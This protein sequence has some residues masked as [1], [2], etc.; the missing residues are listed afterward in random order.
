[1]NRMLLALVAVGGLLVLSSCDTDPYCLTCEEEDGGSDA[2]D[3]ATGG[4]VLLVDAPVDDAPGDVGDAGCLGTELCND[5]DDDCDGFVDEGLSTDRDP[6]NCG[7]CGNVCSPPHA[8]AV[9]TDG[10]CMVGDCDVG[11][12]DLNG[13]PADGCEYR[14]LQTADEDILCD[15]RDNDCDGL[16]DE[17][18]EFDTDPDN[19]GSCGRVC[20][21][22][23]SDASCAM[24]VCLVD[25]CEDG[26]FDIDGR[27]DNGCE[28]ACTLADPAEETCNVRD[29]D[30]D[31]IVDE[32]DPGGGEACGIDVGA[33]TIGTTMCV[34]GRVACTD[35]ITPTTELCNGVDD[36]CDGNVDQGNPEGGRLCGSRLGA[37]VQGREVC[38]DGAISCVGEV[39]GSA[40]TCNAIDD[41]CDGM[42][43]EGNPDG[44]AACGE[45][46]GACE[47]G[48]LTCS[49]GG[50]VCMGG[51]S[52]AFEACNSMDDDCDGMVDEGNPGG[53]ALCGTDL[54]QCRPG[55]QTCNAGTV[56]C[57]GEVTG[58]METCNSLDDDCDGSVDEG[59][60]GGGAACGPTTGECTA[61]MLACRSGTFVCEGGTGPNVETCDGSDEDCDGATDEAFN[62]M[63]DPR[64][65]G[66]CGNSCDADFAIGICDGGT[67]AIGG[68]DDGHI[69][70]NGDPSDGCEYACSFAGAEVCNGLDDDCDMVVD[71][72]LTPPANFCLSRGVCTGTTAVCGGA[73]G[74][75]CSYP[76]T[77]EDS[78][79][80]CDTLDNDC[81]GRTDEAYPLA[82]TSCSVGIG[83]CEGVGSYECN[84]TEDGVV[85]NAVPADVPDDE[86]CNALDDD[87]DGLVDEVGVDDLGTSWRDAITADA[88]DTVE[89][90]LGGGSSMLMMQY[91]ASRPDASASS[92]GSNETLAC[93]RPGVLPW[94]SVTWPEARDACCAMNPGGACPGAGAPGWQ[95]CD[96]PD[97]QTSCE[98]GAG[99]CNWAYEAT[100]SSSQPVAC[101]GKE[102][103]SDPGLPGDQDAVA[104]AGAFPM[105]R[106]IWG[107]AGSIYDLSGNVKEW[108]RTAAGSNIYEQRGGA[109]N[110]IEN[111]RACGWDFTVANQ[112]FAHPATG[113]R[114]C[115]Y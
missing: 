61:G 47:A 6:N 104:T 33:C 27:A 102:R 100:C 28:Y 26:F 94:T 2:G 56:E 98:S 37:C 111:G 95:L 48:A 51:V 24:S 75:T 12:L 49:G 14:C 63:S 77:F 114:C 30:C 7:A 36:D 40:E 115:M 93:S 23:H 68:C 88:F 106:A 53:G 55:T 85:C 18:V 74:Y 41:D 107:A 108:T 20:R 42:I 11:F 35:S 46:T 83:A 16:V 39:M 9:C 60:P 90:D 34:M 110:T 15:L 97:W 91:E 92:G 21:F 38:S 79:T 52:P 64:H 31:G 80:R 59:N 109:Y 62:F 78:E 43:D 5:A 69:D 87:C 67:C 13:D 19:C 96:A 81:D 58:S 113:F 103:D 65:C 3:A 45:T 25:M 44:G 73:A 72:T 71:E 99:G 29:D 54:G 76:S 89:V 86:E 4:D 10:V 70:A 8:F 1:M 50:L 66:G 105:C 112:D 84:G 82:G 101:N 32:G 22:P 57:I 17:D